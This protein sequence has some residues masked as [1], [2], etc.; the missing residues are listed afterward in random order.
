MSGY[1]PRNKDIVRYNGYGHCKDGVAIVKWDNRNK[2]HYYIDT[3]W[4]SGSDSE[5]WIKAED[6]ELLFNLNDVREVKEWEWKDYDKSDRYVLNSEHGYRK[7]YYV[8]LKVSPSILQK[9]ENA[10]EKQNEARQA[11]DSAV[12]SYRWATEEVARLEAIKGKPPKP[13]PLKEKE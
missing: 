10:Y 8:K 13:S 11:I 7:S 12:S 3:Y 9:L 6:V 1:K 4:Y 2:K 5:V